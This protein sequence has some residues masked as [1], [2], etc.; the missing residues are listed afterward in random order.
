MEP[1]LDE[2]C[3][4]W[5]ADALYVGIGATILVL[6]RAQVQRRRVSRFLTQVFDELDRQA[7]ADSRLNRR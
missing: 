1:G 5:V 7:D 2:P 3:P 4:D 6:Q